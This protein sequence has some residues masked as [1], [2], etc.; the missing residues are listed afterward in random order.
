MENK[1]IDQ[2]E[3]LK[4]YLGDTDEKKKKKKKKSKTGTKTVKIIDDDIDLKN[5]R[6][7]EEGEFDI[8]LN[9]ED[10]PQIAGIIDERGPVDFTDKKRWKIITENEEGD[11]TIINRTINKEKILQ[12]DE[13][14][15]NQ[16]NSDDSNLS[17]RSKYSK[18]KNA[19]VSPRRRSKNDNSDS[20]PPRSRHSKNK[21]ADLSP[22]RTSQHK[23]KD[24]DSDLSPP[25]QS[26]NNDSDLSPP[27]Q[28]KKNYDDLDLSSPRSKHS[29]NKHVNSRKKFKDDIKDSDSNLSPPRQYKND[30]DLSPPRQSR[31]N[32]ND[33]DLSPPRQYRN[34]DS[35]LD[36]P[37]KIMKHSTHSI[38]ERS[39]RSSRNR[40]SDSNFSPSRKRKQN[41]DADLYEN[42]R[43]KRDPNSSTSRYKEHRSRK[44]D[45]P[46]SNSRRTDGRRDYYDKNSS[47]SN[48]EDVSRSSRIKRKDYE[49]QNHKS[50]SYSDTREKRKK[51]RWDT[52]TDNFE[53]GHAENHSK[54]RDDRMTKTL[55]G[56]TAGFQ[57]AKE[58]REEIEAHKQR[59]AELFN[60]LSNE[61]SG[62]GQAAILRDK[63]TGRKRNL[64]EE[65]AKNREQEKKQQEM[66]EKYVK[67]GKGL[68]QVEDREEKLKNDLYEI[69]KPL[70]R[71]A[72]DAD[73][74]KQLREQ[75]R[76]GDP[77]L[78]YIKQKQIKEGKRNPD[79]IQYHGSFAPNRFRIKPGY[80]WDGVDRSNGY[81]KKWFETQNAKVARQEEAYKWSTSDM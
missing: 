49:D 38:T 10:A 16:N 14:D 29:K 51:S 71:Y 44:E 12:I 81:E 78:K 35:D 74:D 70:A 79:P 18:N 34:Y 57:A 31:N 42:R 13:T 45:S 60:K 64:E 65:A 61:E 62:R 6:P 24:N 28:S 32:D 26:R 23:S 19:D 25:R 22:R 55:D 53:N 30:S 68:K 5:M 52:E 36:V 1:I 80:R 8:L 17:P 39:C 11:L 50:R 41:L 56:K 4:K 37:R 59:D 73:L 72:D 15:A 66:N 40:N 69:N 48:R 46:Y 43:N 77:M 67:W 47:R 54:N 2:K 21:Q 20:S 58:L 9:G 3:Y 7:I 76:E 33:S 27:R 75:E 63:Q